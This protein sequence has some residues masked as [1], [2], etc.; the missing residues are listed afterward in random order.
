MTTHA[1]RPLFDPRTGIGEAIV[2]VDEKQAPT[3]SEAG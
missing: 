1:P 2:V 3:N